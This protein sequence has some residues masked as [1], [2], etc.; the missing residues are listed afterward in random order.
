MLGLFVLIVFILFIL[1]R[2]LSSSIWLPF[3]KTLKQLKVFKIG[4]KGDA[5][6]GYSNIYEFDELNKS[7]N[8]MIHKIQ[9]DFYNLKEFTENASHEIQTPIAIIK[10]KLE[11]ILQDKT[12]SNQRYQQVQ[13]AYKSVSRLSK[14][15]EAL[16]LLSK[17][18]NQQ[19]PNEIEINLCL[20][21]K[22]RLAF[23]EEMIE[24]KQIEIIYNTGTP[25][26]IKMNPY[27][28]EILINNLLGNAI[29][30]NIENGRIIVT[31]SQKQLIISN[32]GQPLTIAPEK[33]FQRFVK[34]NTT[35]KSTGLGLAIAFQICLNS[36]L[37]LHYTYQN[38]LH[39]IIIS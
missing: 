4:Q 26:L 6:F 27:L 28:A 39:N 35:N 20:L 11:S 19:F 2:W 3:Y 18:E 22:Q 1:N 37:S 33:L 36:H 38:G 31:S 7:L 21:I 23:I 29:K 10:S 14:L 17:I 24:F 15:N 32:T 30:H 13:S 16:L 25:M 34:Y 5:N 8:T 9:S 12:L